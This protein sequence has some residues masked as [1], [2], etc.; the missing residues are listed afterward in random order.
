MK[1]MILLAVAIVSFAAVTSC[2]NNDESDSLLGKWEYLKQ[3]TVTNGQEVLTDYIPQTG[4]SKNYSM[5]TSTTIMDHTFNG[6]DCFEAISNQ[7]YTREGNILTVTGE[8]N[9]Y[10]FEIKTL[11]STTLKIYLTNIDS[12]PSSQVF[13]FKRIN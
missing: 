8:N 12:E 4:C 6:S 11:N 7:P 9:L 3:G 13:V 10:T 2:S 5:I 1:K